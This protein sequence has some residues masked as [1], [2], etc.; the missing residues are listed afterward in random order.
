MWKE[1]LLNQEFYQNI[2]LLFLLIITLFLTYFEAT[3]LH[4]IK[5]IF[6]L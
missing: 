4:N 6:Q 5:I 2:N 3:G 1:L